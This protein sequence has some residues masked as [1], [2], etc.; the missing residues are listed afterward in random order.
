MSYQL[1][2]FYTGLFAS[3]HC[4]AMCGPL[5]LSLPF[6]NQ[7]V[8]FSIFQKV[9]Y[10]IG[11]ILMYGV[12][13]L[14]IGMV[15]MGF[16]WL[17]LQQVLSL[18]TGVLLF[19]VGL[20]Y[21]IL[22]KRNSKIL[23]PKLMRILTNLLGKQLS[24]PYGSFF[25]GVLNGLLP[26]GMV[27]MAMGQAINLPTATDSGKFMLFFG[28]GTTPLL[29]LTVLSPLFFRKYRAPAALMP[30]LFLIAGSFLI[31]RGL[32][33][34]IPYVSHTIENNTGVPVCN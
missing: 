24:K 7:S 20:R 12:I 33:L 2:A 23:F 22:K 14:A 17:G 15:G 8:W 16:G 11:R 3:L 30:V 25:G 26:C 6:S 28:L 32:N 31:L 13:G 21:F 29:F 9:L 5:M 19:A 27:Y 10:Q 4:V 18:I 34:D 1:L